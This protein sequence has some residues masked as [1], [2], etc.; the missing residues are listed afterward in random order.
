[1]MQTW[2]FLTKLGDMIHPA[3][4]E[5]AILWELEKRLGE[6]SSTL[7]QAANVAAEVDWYW[8]KLPSNTPINVNG[9]RNTHSQANDSDCGLVFYSMVTRHMEVPVYANSRHFL[10]PT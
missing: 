8:L 7:R 3:D 2:T 9:D 1:M 5:Q 4:M 6:F 10:K